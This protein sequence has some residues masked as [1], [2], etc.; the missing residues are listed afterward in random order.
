MCVYI[1]IHM[2]IYYF[3]ILF[4]YRLLQNIECAI[5]KS[6]LSVLLSIVMSIC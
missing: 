6:L 3:Q 2:P 4:H 1:R 5:Q